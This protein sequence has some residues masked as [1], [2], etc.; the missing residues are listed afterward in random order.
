MRRRLPLAPWAEGFT[1][2]PSGLVSVRNFIEKIGVHEVI[3]AMEAAYSSR[4]VRRGNEFK[5]FCGICWNK[6]REAQ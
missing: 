5:Y 4:K 6:I 1:L 2:S 3:N